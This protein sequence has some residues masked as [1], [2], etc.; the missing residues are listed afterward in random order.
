[1]SWAEERMLEKKIEMIKG[2]YPR[3]AIPLV[4]SF[5]AKL[6][7]TYPEQGNTQD[8]VLL[9]ELNASG[10]LIN[11]G[12]TIELIKYQQLWNGNWGTTMEWGEGSIVI[13]NSVSIRFYGNSTT[14]GPVRY[15]YSMDLDN[16]NPS[17]TYEVGGYFSGKI[18]NDVC[19]FHNLKVYFQFLNGSSVSDG[20]PIK[21]S[22][23]VDITYILL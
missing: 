7:G 14:T 4:R 10:I 3:D 11:A 16:L 22:A 8:K 17:A 20:W 13:D 21:R 6:D 12:T 15:T 19:S 18:V 23:S 5:S 2:V 1:M 9:Y